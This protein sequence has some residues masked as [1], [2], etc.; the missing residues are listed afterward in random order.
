MS[1]CFAILRISAPQGD[2]TFSCVDSN[3]ANIHILTCNL[4][5]TVEA[6]LEVYVAKSVDNTFSQELRLAIVS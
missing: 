5:E 4:T 2:I 1:A 6:K 3:V